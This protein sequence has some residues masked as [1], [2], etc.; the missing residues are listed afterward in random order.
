MRPLSA[1]QRARVSLGNWWVGELVNRWLCQQ[2]Q[3]QVEAEIIEKDAANNCLL[4]VLYDRPKS[5]FSFIRFLYCDARQRV[6]QTKTCHTSYSASCSSSTLCSSSVLLQHISIVFHCF[7]VDTL[8]LPNWIEW[9]LCSYVTELSGHIHSGKK[10][11]LLE[12]WTLFKWCF[13]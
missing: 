4:R 12:I 10:Y 11:C 2:W 3:L 8:Y 5:R 1:I 7:L 13:Y 9:D 6:R